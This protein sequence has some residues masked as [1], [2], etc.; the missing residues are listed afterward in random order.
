MIFKFKS[1]RVD[2]ATK[3]I[4]DFVE[5]KDDWF[6]V[7][8]QKSKQVRSLPQNKILLGCGCESSLSAYRIHFRRNSSG[9]GKNVS[10]L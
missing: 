8:I 9:T 4:A 6:V 10:F 1:N 5:G 3:K 7:E 2:I